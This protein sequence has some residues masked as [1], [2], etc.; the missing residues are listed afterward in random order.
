MEIRINEIGR[1][2]EGEN[3]DLLIKIVATHPSDEDTNYLIFEWSDTDN[4]KNWDNWVETY[5]DVCKYFQDSHYKIEWLDNDFIEIPFGITGCITEGENTGQLIRVEGK[6]WDSTY[7]VR[8]ST[9]E[10]E[11]SNS[12]VIVVENEKSIRALF[13]EKN[14][15]VRCSGRDHK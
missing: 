6:R 14:W 1:I 12:E 15:I 9:W 7:Q 11:F 3:A 2:L 10:N 13:K 4:T 8:L 5:E